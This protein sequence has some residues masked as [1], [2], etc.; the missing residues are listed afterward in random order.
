MYEQVLSA[1][2]S[3]LKVRTV[4][5]AYKE[6]PTISLHNAGGPSRRIGIPAFLDDL[7][8]GSLISKVQLANPLVAIWQTSCL[9]LFCYWKFSV[10]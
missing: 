8:D 3:Y 7:E 5:N 10:L 4:A 9:L 2:G 6:P 1:K